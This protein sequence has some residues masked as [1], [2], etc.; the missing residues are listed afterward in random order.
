M[1]VHGNLCIKLHFYLQTFELRIIIVFLDNSHNFKFGA[2]FIRSPP[3]KLILSN[4]K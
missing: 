3:V 4:P 1:V 2:L